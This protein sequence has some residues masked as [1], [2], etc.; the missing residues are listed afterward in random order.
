MPPMRV[1]LRLVR[2]LL[3]L[4]E[5]AMAGAS[6]Y[7]TAVMLLGY[8]PREVSPEPHRG[9]SPRFGL[10]VCARDEEASV[11]GILSDLLAQQYPPEAVHVILVAHNCTDRTALVG[12]ELGAHVAEVRSRQ[13]GKAAAM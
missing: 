12:R 1:L 4:A 13:T 7:Q 5:A 6:F 2:G 10:L 9:R 3:V 11:G 8:S